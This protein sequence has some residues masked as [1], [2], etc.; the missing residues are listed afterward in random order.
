MASYAAGV[1]PA[2]IV[3]NA[4]QWLLGENGYMG[5]GKRVARL[6]GP[7]MRR[8]RYCGFGAHMSHSVS[9]SG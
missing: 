8:N 9:V 4:S 6:A 2:Q 1:A 3:A 5:S 7:L